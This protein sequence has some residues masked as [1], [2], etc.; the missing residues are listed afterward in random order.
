MK[1]TPYFKL[2]FVYALNPQ[3]WVQWYMPVFPATGDAKAWAQKFEAVIC[4]DCA[5]EK[6][7]HS[8]LGSIVRPH[9][10]NK[11]ELNP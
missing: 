1:H 8:S 5:C 10:C 4:Y 3:N 11:N 7:L 2:Y 9:L 6:P